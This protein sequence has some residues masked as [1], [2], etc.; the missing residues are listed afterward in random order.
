MQGVA[1]TVTIFDSFYSVVASG[2]SGA[3]Q[4]NESQ[5]TNG[6]AFSLPESGSFTGNELQVWLNGALI[7]VSES[8]SYVGSGTMTQISLSFDG[9]AGDTIRFTKYRNQ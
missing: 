4:I 7:M 8:Y 5:V 9:K 1:S 3:H 6:T 2:A